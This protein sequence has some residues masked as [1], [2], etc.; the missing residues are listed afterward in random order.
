MKEAIDLI[1]NTMP[2]GVI[3]FNNRLDI[4]YSNKK[5]SSF[6][7]RYEIPHE[8]INVSTRIFKSINSNKLQEQFP[9]EIYITKKF[10]NSQS[11]WIFRIFICE[12][13]KPLVV[14]FIIEEP[15]SN[16]L[17]MNQ[18]RQQF[19]LTRREVDILRRVVDGLMNIEI[20]EALEIA[21]QTVKDHLSNI[22]MKTGFKNRLALVRS[23][24]N[25]QTQ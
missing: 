16:N 7:S 14:V 5:A 2:S 10:D 6:L 1:L 15:I 24:L 23:L 19:R 12:E 9:G 11:M 17:D 4:V 21:E 25:S 3:V 22:Y 13:P 20:A 18:V 8:V